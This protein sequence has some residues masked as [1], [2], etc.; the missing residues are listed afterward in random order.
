[1]AGDFP[2]VELREVAQLQ[3]GFA[4]KSKDWADSG[5]PVVKIANVLDGRIDLLGCSFVPRRIAEQAS[6]WTLGSG[7]ILV[8]MTGYVGTVGRVR[9]HDLP[10]LLNQ[11]V[12]RFVPDR[13][14]IEPD[15]LFFSVRNPAIRTQWGALANGSAQANISGK[16]ICSVRIPLPALAEQRRIAAILGALDD[17]IELNR[18]MNQTLEEMGQ[19]LTAHALGS[20]DPTDGDLL[21]G[22]QRTS[23]GALVDEYGGGVQTGPFGSQLHA[24]DYVERGIPSVM[25]RDI[26]LDRVSVENIARVTDADAERLSKHRLAPGDIVYS[27]RGDVERRA[28][29]TEREEGWLCGTGCLRVRLEG[30]VHYQYLYWYLGHPGVRSWIVR[31][32]HGATMPNLNTRIL[33][34]L[35]VAVPPQAEQSKLVSVLESLFGRREANHDEMASLADLRDTLLPKLISG[36][37]R[38]PEAERLVEDAS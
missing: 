1:M 20:S 13:S 7:D 18:K 22:W 36:E 4:F 25:P 31:H 32:S 37:L 17:K 30:G 29:A 24:A 6:R 26:K 10:A 33:R 8:G 15:F 3:G 12:G 19:T 34:S 11:R 28:L 5:I 9:Q 35:P 16:Q 38:V 2:V 14:R 27:R 23:L 21:P